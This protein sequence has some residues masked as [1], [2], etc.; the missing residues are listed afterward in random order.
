M[1]L[2]LNLALTPAEISTQAAFPCPIAFMAC[3]FSPY[4]L[5]LSGIPTVLPKGSMLIVTD[6]MD[7]QG[8]SADLVADQ[9]QKAMDD[10]Q[11]ESILLDFQR[12]PAPEAEWMIQH[13][14][15]SLPCPVAVTEGYAAKLNCPVFLSPAPLHLPLVE[16]IAPWHNREIWLEAALGQCDIKVTETGVTATSQFPPD[17]LSGGFYEESLCCQYK[18]K[19]NKDNVTFILFDTPE[20][21]KKKLELAALLGVKR[22]VGLWQELGDIHIK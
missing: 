19:V 8:H 10:L 18:T 4:T 11:Y 7:C 6:R 2:P 21:L 14:V 16:H 20:S 3:S 12:P 15:E 1:V 13:I 22:A 5:G 9:L 17:G